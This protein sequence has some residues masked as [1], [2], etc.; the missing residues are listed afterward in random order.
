MPLP[1]TARPTIP[2]VGQTF[3][4]KGGFSTVFGQCGCEGKG[5][6]ALV[7]QAPNACPECK[8]VFVVKSFAMTP[9]GQ[10]MAEIAVMQ[11]PALVEQ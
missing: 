4:L 9:E 1:F 3:T 6:V 7:G 2:I 8:R 10:V 11:A 5:Y